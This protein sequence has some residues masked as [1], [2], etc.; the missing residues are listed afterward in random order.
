M[1]RRKDMQCVAHNTLV[2]FVSRHNNIAGRWTMGEFAMIAKEHGTKTVEF[3][4]IQSG[5]CPPT[6]YFNSMAGDIQNIVD[7]HMRAR[8]MPHK[9]IKNIRVS[10][11]FSRKQFSDAL[12]LWSPEYLFRCSISIEDNRGRSYT[13]TDEGFC[14]PSD[15]W[16]IIRPEWMN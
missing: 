14:V 9:W 7:R 16:K 11:K 15:I 4:T 13:A 10:V 8:R 5:T 3:D 1:P 2:W 12:T 6:F